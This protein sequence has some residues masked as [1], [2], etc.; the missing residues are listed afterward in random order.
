MDG[1]SALVDCMVTHYK[2]KYERMENLL[3]AVQEN[4]RS[5]RQDYNSLTNSYQRLE[6]WAEEQE[7]R[8]NALH[9][10]INSFI[11]RN[12]PVVRRDLLESFNEVADDLDIDLDQI[13][14]NDSEE[15]FDVID[16]TNDF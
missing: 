4:Y 9:D 16:L 12:G 6:T 11:D 13:L 10:V 2:E 8:A 14:D 15:E 7:Q 1:Y 3:K 5:L